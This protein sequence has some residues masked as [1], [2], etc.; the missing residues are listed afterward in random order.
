ME[1]SSLTSGPSTGSFVAN[2]FE[3]FVLPDNTGGQSTDEPTGNKSLALVPR[4]QGESC[5]A[6]GLLVANADSPDQLINNRC[7]SLLQEI[8]A[9]QQTL[10]DQKMQLAIAN[11]TGNVAGALIAT[12]QIRHTAQRLVE[13][14]DDFLDTCGN[15]ERFADQVPTMR[16]IR[17]AAQ[18][19]LNMIDGA[20]EA[21]Q[22]LGEGALWLVGGVLTGI[23][24]LLE[25]MGKLNPAGA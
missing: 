7:Q 6:D 24:F 9:L 16:N 17:N 8:D 20:I 13:L 1:L 22:K 18:S 5:P 4:P 12:G 25:L 3:D 21:L 19:S 11:M 14:I 10:G 2:L 15:R 23:G